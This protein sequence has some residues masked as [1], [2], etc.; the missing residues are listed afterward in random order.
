MKRNQFY[1]GAGFTYNTIMGITAYAGVTL[2]NIDAQ[3]SYTLGLFGETD[4]LVWYKNEDYLG[5]VSY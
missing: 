4:P 2:Y 1:V 3:V 5:K